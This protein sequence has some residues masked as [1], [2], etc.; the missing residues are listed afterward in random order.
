MSTQ[1]PPLAHR[2]RGI[3]VLVTGMLMGLALAAGIVAVVVWLL[4]TTSGLTAM[5]RVATALTPVRIRIESPQGSVRYGFAIGRLTVAVG[6]TEVD[7]H[8]L[9]GTLIDFGIQPLRF[10]FSALAAASVDVRVKP[11]NAAPSGPLSSIASPVAV[12]AAHLQVSEFALRIGADPEP[13]LIAARAIDGELAI[14]PDGY[15]I[16]RA[17]FEFGRVDA[18][19]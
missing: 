17:A 13:T 7:I 5:A 3:A 14:G 18:P 10:D 8:D 16:G 4:Q 2:M 15:K 12:S 11:G 1:P 19:L 9:R 6:T